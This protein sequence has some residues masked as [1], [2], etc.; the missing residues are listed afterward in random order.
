MCHVVL[1]L[2]FVSQFSSLN[3]EFRGLT[4]YVLFVYLQYLCQAGKV[5]KGVWNTM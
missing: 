4:D 1:R 3:C 5:F 2:V